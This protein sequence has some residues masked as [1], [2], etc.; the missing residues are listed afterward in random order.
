M[1]TVAT[2]IIPGQTGLTLQQYA[3]D[4][5]NK[6]PGKNA[7]QAFLGYAEAHPNLTPPEAAQAF[8]LIIA[9]DG[10]DRAV[11]IGIGDLARVTKATGPAA[12]AAAKAV[13]AKLPGITS[14]GAFLNLF[15][16]RDFV[17]R[18]AEGAIGIALIVVAL[19][20]MLSNTS[21]AGKA[22]HTAAKAAFLA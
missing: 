14:I 18:L 16:S 9:F 19:D 15:T 7:G 8:A 11:A 20:K 12:G 6:F 17:I 2:S 4:F 3:Q 22:V 5:D 10:V 1:V 21:T 13:Q